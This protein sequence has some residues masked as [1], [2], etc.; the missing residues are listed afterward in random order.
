MNHGGLPG[1]FFW[2]LDNAHYISGAIALALLAILAWWI[3]R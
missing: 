1:W 3:L 2:L